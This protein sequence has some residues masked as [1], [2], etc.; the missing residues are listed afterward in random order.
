MSDHLMNTYARMPAAM[1]RGEGAWLWDTEGRRYLDAVSGLGVTGLGHA[2]PRVTRT[3]AEQAGTLIHTSNLFRIPW[4]EA[5]ADRLADITGMDRAF[6]CNSGT[7]AVECAL[8]IIRLAGHERGIETPG[9][10]VMDNSFHGRT[11]AA[12]SATGSRKAQAGFEPLV[13]GFVRVPFDDIAAIERIAERDPSITAVLVEPVQGEAGIRV[14][15]PGY[16]A[17]LRTICN[18]RGWL[19]A[20]DEIQSGLCRTGR[21]YAHQHDEI[22]PDLL[23]SAKALA[24]GLPIGACVAAGPA[25]DLLSPGR[26]GTTFGGNP[27]ACRTAC[28][29]LDVM[30]EDDL[31]ARA[32]AL[33]AR[34]IDGF[35]TQ[36]DG[37]KTVREI[38]GQGLML[39]IECDRPVGE[40]KDRALEQGLIINVTRENVIRLLPPLILDDEQADQIVTT[41]SKLVRALG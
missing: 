29:V 19:L 26:H 9:V 13:S 41:V 11:L 4:Q 6:I 40:L 17:K 3:I 18:R 28:T 23:T 35:R 8:K 22:R 36:L 20:V 15:T 10:I 27:L 32:E 33:G 7:E 24:N 31:A 16:L 30:R 21:W 25:A 34:M 5:L 12:L 38:R 2:H 1:E 14:P 37:V 39:G